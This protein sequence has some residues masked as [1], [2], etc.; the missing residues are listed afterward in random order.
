MVYWVMEQGADVMYEK[1][2][3]EFSYAFFVRKFERTL[4]RNPKE[5]NV[6]SHGCLGESC[7]LVLKMREEE[8]GG[9]SGSRGGE[10]LTIRPSGAWDQSSRRAFVS[11]S[12]ESRLY[13]RGSCLQH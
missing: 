8:R 4:I 13:G 10:E 6:S 2:I 5:N 3:E 9:R 11:R 12:S 1:R 7:N